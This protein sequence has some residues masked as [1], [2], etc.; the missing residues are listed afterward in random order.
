[1]FFLCILHIYTRNVK[2]IFYVIKTIAGALFR[3]YCL[4]WFSKTNCYLGPVFP[5]RLHVGSWYLF[6]ANNL[7]FLRKLRIYMRNVKFIFYVIKSIAG[8]L[9][10]YYCLS[11]FSKTNFT[12]AQFFLQDCM[13]AAGISLWQIFYVSYANYAFI[14]VTWNLFFM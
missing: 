11:W 5:T 7:C 6:I 3:D 14:C 10:R 8:A 1:M 12:G 9:F 13:W 4:S 2:F